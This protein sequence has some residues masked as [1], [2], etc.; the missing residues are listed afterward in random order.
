MRRQ[1]SSSSTSIPADNESDWSDD[2]TSWTSPK[3]TKRRSLRRYR[4][5]GSPSVIL[6]E[7]TRPELSHLNIFLIISKPS[8]LQVIAERGVLEIEFN[9]LIWNTKDS[10]ETLFFELPESCLNISNA[11]QC[12]LSCSMNKNLNLK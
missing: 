4:R 7:S 12:F 6:I 10:L 11:T 5:S 8:F 2:C 3:R 9:S 1:D